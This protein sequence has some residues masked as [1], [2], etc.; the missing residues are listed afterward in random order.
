MLEAFA[1]TASILTKETIKN[2]TECCY[3]FDCPP[4]DEDVQ[5]NMHF[6]YGSEEKAYKLCFDGV[7]SVYPMA[8][9]TIVNGYVHLTYSVKETD[10]YIGLLQSI[11]KSEFTEVD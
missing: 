2:E 4:F 10:Q 6:L 8:G 1:E 7:K 9:Y 5:R 11:C 3:T